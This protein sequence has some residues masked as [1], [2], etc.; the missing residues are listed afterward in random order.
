MKSVI[1]LFVCI[2]L[3]ITLA[4]FN[5]DIS[6][7]QQGLARA[8]HEYNGALVVTRTTL[9]G[10]ASLLVG[11]PLFQ[12]NFAWNLQNS[13]EKFLES[14]LRPGEM[15]LV[16]IFDSQCKLVTSAGSIQAPH[17]KCPDT[18]I[19][20][21]R[22]PTFFWESSAG[23]PLLNLATSFEVQGHAHTLVSSVLLDKQWL[24]IHP[25]LF[26]QAKALKL[27]FGEK[28]AA[29]RRVLLQEGLTDDGRWVAALWS[30]NFVSQIA[31]YLTHVARVD[32]TS[33]I[34]FFNCLA[35]AFGLVICFDFYQKIAVM[36]NRESSFLTWCRTLAQSATEPKGDLQAPESLDTAKEWIRHAFQ[37]HAD[38]A[39]NLATDIDSGLNHR[40]LIEEELLEVREQILANKHYEILAHQLQ[41]VLSSHVAKLDKMH[42]NAE[43]ITDTLS[44]GLMHHANTL[45]KIMD[46]WQ[47]ALRE[48]SPRK[49][50]RTLAEMSN[51]EGA[52]ALDRTLQDIFQSSG[53]I[54]AQALSLTINAQKLVG[55]LLDA[56]LLS[57]HWLALVENS[58]DKAEKGKLIDVILESHYLVKLVPDLPV[59]ELSS[60]FTPGLSISHLRAPKAT[61]TSAFY[62][63][64]VALLLTAKELKWDPVQIRIHSKQKN[65]HQILILSLEPFGRTKDAL[66]LPCGAS[67]ASHYHYDIATKLMDPFGIQ[68]VKLPNFGGLSAFMVSWQEAPPLQKSD[69]L[70]AQHVN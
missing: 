66:S 11:E 32:L 46:D 16:R 44:Q 26:A 49:F 18:L 37:A 45:G 20:Q 41:S 12:Q 57:Q 64:Y 60:L 63:I 27:V 4:S 24:K 35:M 3:A 61:I 2:C 52:S 58:P 54:T 68:I 51:D 48:H 59:H 29:G 14:N 8:T 50:F 55:E 70:L 25:A 15:D 19:K 65:A 38:I 47:D 10:L 9:A 17:A 53:Q 22:L 43:D 62:H 42:S 39:K 34:L 1:G 28:D 69:I 31:L 33:I 56:T 6:L 13:V 5:K 40:Q 30:D 36:K 21:N 7:R 23:T 67:D